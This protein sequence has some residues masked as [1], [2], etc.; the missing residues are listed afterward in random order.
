MLDTSSQNSFV[1]YCTTIQECQYT[2]KDFNVDY[3]IP[4]NHQTFSNVTYISDSNVHGHV[5]SS[6]PS[7]NSDCQIINNPSLI[8]TQNLDHDTLESN[9][10][11]S[12]SKPNFPAFPWMQKS[13][14]R[15][16]KSDKSVEYKRC[17]Q[18]YSRQQTLELE[19]EFYYNQY[20]TRRRRIE[21]AN[22]VCLSERQIKIWFQ[23]R[24]MKYKK[25]VVLKTNEF[26]S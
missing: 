18:A 26:P 1:N 19:K 14:M 4:S 23:N 16:N 17:R 10:G 7:T 20:L 5:F 2:I 13:N 6:S 11:L 21:I 15:K 24:R 9:G 22:S 25:D 3:S 12:K 8:Q